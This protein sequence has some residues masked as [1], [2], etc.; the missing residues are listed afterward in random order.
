MARIGDKFPSNY[1]KAS[2]LNGR[3]V[4]VTI[5][6]VE[7]EQVGRDKEWKPVVYFQ[8]KDKGVVLNRTNA[9][10][11]TQIAGTDETDEWR[12]VAVA[13]FATMV[14]FGGESVEAIRIKSPMRA[15][16]K[17]PAPLLQPERRT[18]PR[19]PEP[20]PYDPDEDRSQPAPLREPGDD[21]IQF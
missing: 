5:D 10:A 8:G 13:L 4:T 1:L 20:P 2:D 17:P 7:D 12:G 9:K 16:V 15:A 14:E 3:I 18:A 21:D 19:Q 11:I 6:R